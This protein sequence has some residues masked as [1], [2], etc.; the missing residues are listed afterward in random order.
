MIK[1]RG[2]NSFN[3]ECDMHVALSVCFLN[4]AETMKTKEAYPSDF[5]TKVG[6]LSFFFSV[7]ITFS[8][9][10]VHSHVYSFI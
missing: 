9:S 6:R 7:G 1:T 10:L 3:S 8:F 2:R 4:W 5:I